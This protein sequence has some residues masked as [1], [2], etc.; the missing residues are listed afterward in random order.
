MEAFNT[1]LYWREYALGTRK[2]GA[3][4][5][6]EVAPFAGAMSAYDPNR[7]DLTPWNAKNIIN[8]WGTADFMKMDEDRQNYTGERVTETIAAPA[9]AQFV[10]S[11]GPVKKGVFVDPATGVKHDVQVIRGTQILFF[12][13][14][15]NTPVTPSMTA[16]ARTAIEAKDGANRGP[17]FDDPVKQFVFD[18]EGKN[19]TAL[20]DGLMIDK[21]A[22]SRVVVGYTPVAGDRVAYIYDNA[23][24]PAEQIPSVV[25]RMQK[26][27][28]S[29][30]IRRI[31]YMFS[32]LAAWEA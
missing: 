31:N 24:I 32:K 6:G 12:D 27:P 23:Y 5:I 14:Q 11:F 2:G 7:R 8:G 16:Y 15:E 21:M 18:S 10:A 13:I 20:V 4:G 17:G 9:P 3:G 26:R 28:V 29:A 30:K 22:P 19:V 25:M 1:V